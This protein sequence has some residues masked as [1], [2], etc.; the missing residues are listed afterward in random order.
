VQLGVPASD[1]TLDAAYAFA[2]L[3]HASTDVACG[4]VVELETVTGFVEDG[5]F[6]LSTLTMLTSLAKAGSLDVSFWGSTDPHSE[7]IT[8][9]TPAVAVGDRA[10]VFFRE[11]DGVR[12][13]SGKGA[14]QRLHEGNVRIGTLEL[15]PQRLRDA[16][17]PRSRA[18]AGDTASEE[19]TATE[20]EAHD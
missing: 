3:R 12:W 6:P 8:S 20:L 5:P 2:R 7:L 4:E 13:W 14:Y 10:C 1:D 19:A 11:V 16:L 9:A 15:E 17:F 18:A